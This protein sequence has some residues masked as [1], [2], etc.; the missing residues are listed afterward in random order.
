MNSTDSLAVDSIL[1]T[2][3][4]YKTHLNFS[5]SGPGKELYFSFLTSIS[6]HRK[7]TCMDSIVFITINNIKKYLKVTASY[8]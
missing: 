2:H 8:H 3:L 7:R 4:K 6:C 5:R 1:F